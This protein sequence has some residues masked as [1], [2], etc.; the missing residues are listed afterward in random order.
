MS[1][2][3]PDAEPVGE[4]V[5]KLRK[6]RDLTQQELADLVGVSR[7]LVQQI[8]NGKRIPPLALRERLSS[9]LGEQLLTGQEAGD[10]GSDLRMRFNILLGK[11]PAVVERVLVIAQSLVDAASARDTVEPL[12]EIAERQLERAEEVLTQIPSGS[13]QV[14]EWN[15]I[16]DWLTVLG[17]AR[18][19]VRAIHTADLGT[20]GGDVGEDYHEKILQLAADS[21]EVRRLYVIDSI[22]DVF[23]YEDKL[24][25]QARNRVETVLVPRELAPNAQSML[26]VDES[27]VATGEYAYSRRERIVTRFS[28][29]KHDIQFAI[30]RFD[31]LYKLANAGMAIAV[32]EVIAHADLAR[33]RSLAQDDCR[34]EFRAALRRAWVQ[35]GESPVEG[36]PR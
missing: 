35:A 28:S 17:R 30:R 1:R 27:Y 23:P 26:V 19:S 24:W 12:R 6:D 36:A 13:A 22:D 15:T 34:T 33:Y 14:W 32:D 20:I 25:Q 4:R 21:V 8:E 29:L 9:A 18:N 31:Q 3:T 5:R 11:D 2:S 7:S 10:A 16:H